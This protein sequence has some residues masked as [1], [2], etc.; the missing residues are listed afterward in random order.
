MLT[1]S[2]LTLTMGNRK[3]CQSLNLQL[4]AGEV[5]GILGPNGCGK[6]TLLH[7]LCGLRPVTCGE[8]RLG[9]Q[10]LNQLP[11][12]TIARSIGLLFQD[13]TVVF[14]QTVW[15]YCR[16]ARYP[17]LPFLKQESAADIQ[18][19][20]EALRTMELQSHT[21]RRVTQL[22]GGEQRRLAIAALLA[23]T[24][25]IYFLD[26]PANHLDVRYQGLVFGHFRRLADTNNA[27]VMMS[28]HDANLAQH[29]CD[30]VLLMYPDGETMQGKILDM[31]TPE[32]LTRLYRHPIDSIHHGDMIYWQPRPGC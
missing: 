16:A 29:Y 28:L 22:S 9:G 17:H 31:L 30:H 32:H 14:P 11:V 6:T 8:I 3:L 4:R 1:A 13:I 23:Q 25:A 2:R 12:K 10:L 19:I 15:D 24:P 21:R 7:A 20:S 18:I 26:E 5:W 27:V